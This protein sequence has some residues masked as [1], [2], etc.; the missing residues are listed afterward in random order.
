MPTATPPPDDTMTDANAARIA[1]ACRYIAAREDMPALADVAAHA[2]LSAHH[3]HRLFRRLTGVTPRQYAQ[4]LRTQRLQAGLTADGAVTAAALDAGY[5]SNSR[6]YAGAASQLGM[7]PG[8]YRRGGEGMRIH[9]A[10]GHCSL[11]DILVAQSELGLCAILL[12]DD[13]DAL[14]QDLQD[15]FPRADL[16]GGDSD[17]EATVARVIAFVDQPAGSLDL[18]LDIRG[19]TFQQRVWLALRD[20]P[21]GT[22]LS[23]SQ[24]AARIGMPAAVRAIAGAC[25]ANPLAIAIPCHR[26]VRNDGSLSGY[27]WGIGRKRRLLDRESANGVPAP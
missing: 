16:V 2:G 1:A 10:V 7:T 23:Y 25:A 17:F 8:R 13:A 11:G 26:V 22:T 12:G 5:N 3:F 21:P 4:A 9:F 19:T 20:I 27:R 6:L 18:P 15:R 14:L 24:L